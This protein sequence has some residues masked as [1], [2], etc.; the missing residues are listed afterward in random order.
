[1]EDLCLYE[2]EF[3]QAVKKALQN[4][5]ESEGKS[6]PRDLE[7]RVRKSWE[8]YKTTRDKVDKRDRTEKS[9]K[10]DQEDKE[11]KKEKKTAGRWFKDVAKEILED[12]ASKIVLA[13]VYS[14]LSRGAK[15]ST[16]SRE[17]VKDAKVVCLDIAARMSLASVK[18][19][20]AIEN[21]K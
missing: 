13:R 18:A 8:D 2:E 11:D 12:E 14:E 15:L 6:V 5:C 4:A 16:P 9:D 21:P 7:E 17:K 1:M 20:R 10:S 19:V 3:V